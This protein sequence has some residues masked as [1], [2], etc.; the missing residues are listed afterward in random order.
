VTIGVWVAPAGAGSLRLSRIRRFEMLGRPSAAALSK[1]FSKRLVAASPFQ[2][3]TLPS[4]SI[5]RTRQ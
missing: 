3:P 5:A 4:T 1:T 2:T